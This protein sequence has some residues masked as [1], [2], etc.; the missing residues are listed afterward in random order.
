L[1]FEL[2]TAIVVLFK[3]AE[4]LALSSEN[5]KYQH[6]FKKLVLGK[7]QIQASPQLPPTRFGRE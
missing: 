1:I 6:T 7:Q 2:Q 4:P 3:E 5:G